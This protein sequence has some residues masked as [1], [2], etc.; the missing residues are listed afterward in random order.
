MSI[1]IQNFML[2]SELNEY[3]KKA[4][5]KVRHIKGFFPTPH[6]L[7]NPLVLHATH[8][9]PPASEPECAGALPGAPHVGGSGRGGRGRHRVPEPSRHSRQV[10][11]CNRPNQI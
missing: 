5:E 8:L 10:T 11:V 1:R 4:P 6:F 7:L 9:T 2:I 3:F